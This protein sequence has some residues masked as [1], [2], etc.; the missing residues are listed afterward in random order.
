MQ[1]TFIPKKDTTENFVGSALNLNHLTIP[2]RTNITQMT[3][4]AHIDDTSTLLHALISPCKNAV[5]IE[6][7]TFK[8]PNTAITIAANIPKMLIILSLIHI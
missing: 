7:I 3:N 1:A 4:S 8:L 6:L 2:N 5:A